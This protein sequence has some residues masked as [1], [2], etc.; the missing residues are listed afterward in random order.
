MGK[1]EN[2]PPNAFVLDCPSREILIRLAE[3]WTFLI[4]IA[5]QDG[6]KR[7]GALKRQV[8]GVSQKMLTQT[9]RNLEADGLVI[10]QVYDEMPLRVEY[11]LT[12]LGHELVPLNTAIKKWTED[13]MRKILEAR[14]NGRSGAV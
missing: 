13:N 2:I 4:V 7:F 10:R 14:I 9:L 1:M 11:Q 12:A 3:K 8:E 6:P 5:L